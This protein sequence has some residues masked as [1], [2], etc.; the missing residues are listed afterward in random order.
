MCVGKRNMDVKLDDF[1][2]KFYFDVNDLAN[3]KFLK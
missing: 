1:M 2:A 3:F